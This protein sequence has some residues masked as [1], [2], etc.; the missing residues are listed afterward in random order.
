M[1]HRKWRISSEKVN[2]AI[3]KERD[4]RER[5]REVCKNNLKILHKMA[6]YVN[7]A[8]ELDN[9][10]FHDDKGIY[11]YSTVPG[12]RWSCSKL[13]LHQGRAYFKDNLS[14]LGDRLYLKCRKSQRKF[15][16]CKGRAIVVGKAFKVIYSCF[17]IMQTFTSTFSSF[18]V[19][20]EMLKILI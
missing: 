3:R 12:D 16:P 9:L 2:K 15:G 10:F 8:K 7:M 1:F 5:E 17:V 19:K 13:F 18:F 11:N 20:G 4:L 6:P 14:Y